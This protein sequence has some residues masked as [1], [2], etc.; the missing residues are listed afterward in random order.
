MFEDLHTYMMSLQKILDLNP[1]VIY[2]AHGSVIYDP[3]DKLKEY[4]AHRMYREQQILHCLKETPT[5]P[6]TAMDLVEKIYTVG[7]T[8]CNLPDV[9]GG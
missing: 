7:S 4:I 6:L 9:H 1:K 8:F 5:T 3:I 2:P